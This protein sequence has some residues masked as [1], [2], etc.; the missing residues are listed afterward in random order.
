ME[1]DR[2][3]LEPDPSWG[4]VAGMAP[5]EQ[6]ELFGSIAMS[7]TD[8]VVASD[9]DGLVVW[10][11]P[12]AADLFGWPHEQLIGR[13][14]TVLLAEETHARVLAT[15]DRTLRGEHTA[16]FLAVGQR[17]SGE[18]F[19]VSVTPGVRRDT[20]NRPHGT[21]LILR[22]VTE[23]VRLR[24]ELREAEQRLASQEAFFRGLN[25]E[26]SD[27]TMVSDPV[28]NLVYVTPSV[29]QVLGYEPGWGLPPGA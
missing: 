19:E 1:A 14:F 16:P 13:P 6:A 24:R 11:N 23:E 20:Q 5:D 28:G 22:D 9:L 4:L 8:A 3:R 2:E 25:R 26:A 29:K 21:H 27:V 10:V 7:A 15:R 17:R 12:A 18:T